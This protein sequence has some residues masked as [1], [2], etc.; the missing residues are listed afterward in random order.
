M[1]QRAVFMNIR[2]GETDFSYT[3]TEK[4]V[5]IVIILIGIDCKGAQDGE[6]A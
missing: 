1:E 4:L 5:K 6:A 3:K 2:A